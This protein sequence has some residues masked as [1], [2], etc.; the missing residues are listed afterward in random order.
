[1]TASGRRS[2]RTSHGADL[3]AR[4]AAGIEQVRSVGLESAHASAVRHLQPLQHGAVLGVD[5]ADVALVALPRCVPQFA[6][7]PRHA[8]DETVRFDRALDGARLGIDLQDLA[9]AVLPD[10]QAALGPGE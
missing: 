10:P 3:S 9:I 5:A 7:D 6:V 4:S 8:S 2:L 1:M